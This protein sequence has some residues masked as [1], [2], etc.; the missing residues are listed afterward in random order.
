VTLSD[1]KSTI[2]D[3]YRACK[4]A[5][6]SIDHFAIIDDI[7]ALSAGNESNQRCWG[8]FSA[9]ARFQLDACG[10]EK[11]NGDQKKFR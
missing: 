5:G 11:R 9:R 7:H 4:G 6:F 3:V 10:A 8:K 1:K 2:G